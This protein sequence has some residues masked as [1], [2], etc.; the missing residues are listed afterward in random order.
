MKDLEKAAEKFSVLQQ[1]P[2]GV[3]VLREDFVVLFW[4]SCMENW[5]QLPSDRIVGTTI[6]EHFPHLS[7]S[8]YASRLQ[9][10]FLGGPPTIFSSQLHKHFIPAPLPDGQLRIQHTTV[11]AIP[12]GN[13]EAGFY[14]MLS[15]QDVTEL[16]Q[17]V[18]DYRTMRDQALAEV[19]ERLRV[20]EEL[21]QYRNQLEELVEERTAA[22]FKAN[23][24]LRLWGS[25][26][27]NA[28]DAIVVTEAEPISHPGPRILYVNEEFTRQTG[29]AP[30]EV[31]G[32]SPRIL[33][34]PKTDRAQLDKIRAAL[35][36][37][38]PIRIE[39]INYRKDG[40]DFWVEV[41]IV[42][43]ANE[44]GWYSHWVSVQRDIT[45]RKIAEQ[46]Q[47]E[48][49]QRFQAI[50]N[51][52]FQLSG[53][54]KP[55]GTFLLVNQ[56]AQDFCGL[57][58]KE[59]VG[60][61]FWEVQSW[62]CSQEIQ[63]A[64]KA[65]IAEAAQGK[66]I[67]NE[68]TV[69]D[70]KG[71]L[72]TFD[73][74]LKPVF[75]D[76]GQVTLLIPEGRD[77]TNRKQ[78]EQALQS[79]VSGTASV[80][81]EDFFPVLV[82]HLVSALDVRHALV[83]QKIGD[84]LHTLGFWSNDQLQPDITYS[85]IGT[86]CELAVNRGIYRC[87]EKV[88]QCFPQAPALTILNAESYLGVALTDSLGQ[89][90][91]CLCIIDNN[92]LVDE[93][94]AEA[95]LRIFAARAAAEL[96]RQ[97][98]TK[99]LQQ[100][101]TELEM[102]VEERT[103]E[104]RE[105]NKQLQK[106]LAAIEAAGD[107]IAIVDPNGK[108]TYVNN[109]HVTMFGYENASELIGTTWR[110]LY[111][112]DEMSRI[113]Q[114]IFPV[115]L[116]NGHWQGEAIAKKRD[117]TTFSEELSLTSIEGG[118]LIC[119]CRDITERQLAIEALRE[120]EEHFRQLADNITQVFWMTNAQKSKNL[121]L[122]RAYE[123]IWGRSRERVYDRPSS[124][125]DYVHPEDRDRILDSLKRSSH[126]EFDHEYRIIRPDGQE[127]WI[128]DRAFPIRNELG[129]VYR[130]AGIAEDITERRETEQRIKASLEEKEVLLKEIHH[131]VKNNL[132]VICS[133]LQLQSRYTEDPQTLNILKES[134]NRVK[135]MALIHEKLYQSEDL[136]RIDFSDYIH[137]LAKNL[138]YSYTVNLNEIRL[139]L[140]IADVTLNLE[141]AIPCG[142]FI[143]ELVSN[144]LKHAFPQGQQGKICIKL[145]QVN[146]QFLLT[147]SDDGIGLPE[148]ITL[149]NTTSLGLRLVK[150]WSNQLQ[151]SLELDRSY[152]TTFKLKFSELHYTQR[153]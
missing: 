33:Q 111:Y 89:V 30:E 129:E 106:Q 11:T 52:A 37:W 99:A 69:P 147:V 83:A 132:Q 128:R 43:I 135:S 131:R 109:A 114:V 2:I 8:K 23:E 93:P 40:S 59:L 78:A 124:Y 134:Q 10:I 126:G 45:E 120:S 58:E 95:I 107:G 49:E 29:Y 76:M 130:I 39:L 47:R 125:L 150:I 85:I 112:S 117:G 94:R 22:L 153:I 115:L 119:V 18:Q 103:V 48:S 71:K 31:M 21:A 55:D 86:P 92:I 13:E 15:I 41:N 113:E 34:G 84:E 108:Y 133:L 14:A 80:T 1:M 64:V 16:T 151:G 127:R 25:V 54:L 148:H 61:P 66:F 121:Y 137:N 70:A 142:L 6:Y 17:R 138:L 75:D 123:Q 73:F 77:I 144:A 122:S 88:Q 60:M 51:N 91:G 3:C 44:N 140:D 149:S 97:L 24:Q 139:K 152:G 53:L 62:A 136:S 141:T 38:Q 72:T 26:V 56:A 82:R 46:A 20:E 104:L 101:A 110:A 27:I 87:S 98:A 105:L 63:Q 19:K 79:L 67:R 96:E 42:P 145:H 146:E 5:T 116:Q 74:S 12:A 102:R 143:N 118:G 7:Q 35:S 28:N 65:A 9:Q 68:V 90:I 81:G 57:N 4:N 32:Q 50:F 100:F 36:K